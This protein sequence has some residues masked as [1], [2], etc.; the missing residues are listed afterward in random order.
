MIEFK[1]RILVKALRFAFIPTLSVCL[2]LFFGFFSVKDTLDFIGSRNGWA[3]LLRVV[4]AL[5]ELALI[6]FMYIF[7]LNEEKMEL[8]EKAEEDDRKN[9]KWHVWLMR[10][11]DK[12]NLRRLRIHKQKHFHKL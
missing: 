3:I 4:L 9:H 1:I 5:A 2:L 11:K 7:Y 8:E 6:V 12:Q 10:Q